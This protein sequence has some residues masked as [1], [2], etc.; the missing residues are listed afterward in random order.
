M[1]VNFSKFYGYATNIDAKNARIAN[2]LLKLIK[3][4]HMDV[5]E[6]ANS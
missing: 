4:K 2:S 1:T 3:L 6:H 5:M